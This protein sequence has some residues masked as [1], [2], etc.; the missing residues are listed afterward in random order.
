ME[1]NCSLIL[2]SI[3]GTY[4]SYAKLRHWDLDLPSYDN[5]TR[6]KSFTMGCINILVVGVAVYFLAEP[7]DPRT[8]ILTG[9][10]FETFISQA[11]ERLSV[12]PIP[13]VSSG[14]KGPDLSSKNEDVQK[15]LDNLKHMYD[16]EETE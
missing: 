4:I 14:P 3:L 15:Y 10:G 1:I 13:S 11:R 12:P 9:L 7:R 6:Q 16:G 8:A 5:S 2:F